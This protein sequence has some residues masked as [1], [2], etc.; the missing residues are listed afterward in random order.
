MTCLPSE[1]YI[2]LLNIA[3]GSMRAYD[4]IACTGTRTSLDIGYNSPTNVTIVEMGIGNKFHYQ[5]Y[6]AVIKTELLLA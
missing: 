5:L 2:F 6:M 3:L 1:P 4:E